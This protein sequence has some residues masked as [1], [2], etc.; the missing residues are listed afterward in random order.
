MI[1]F[2]A[3]SGGTEIYFKN[4]DEQSE[5]IQDN[6]ISRIEPH[7][8][9]FSPKL[10]PT[11]YLPGYVSGFDTWPPVIITLRTSGTWKFW[12]FVNSPKRSTTTNKHKINKYNTNRHKT[13]KHKVSRRRGLPSLCSEWH[14]GFGKLRSLNLLMASL[15]TWIQFLFSFF[16]M[17]IKLWEWSGSRITG[18]C[19]HIEEQ[20]SKTMRG[21]N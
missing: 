3:C 18:N 13:N 17:W 16:S 14:K 5:K 20:Y 10:P 21:I 4:D 9:G 6:Y 19:S 11:Q 12:Q 8:L 2:I 1:W 15:S 7:T